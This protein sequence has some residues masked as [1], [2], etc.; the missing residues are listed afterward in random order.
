[1]KYFL[2][3]LVMN[4][5][6]GGSGGV[7]PPAPAPAAPPPAAASEAAPAPSAAATPAGGAAQPPAGDIYKPDGLAEHF[8]G[9][10][11]NETIDNLNKA[12]SGYRDRDAANKVPETVEAYSEFGDIAPEIAPHLETL[13]GDP[14]YGRMANYALEN[15]IPLPIYQGMVKQFMSVGQELGMLEPPVD[16]AKERAELTPEAARHLPEAEQR[17]QREKRMNDNYAFV[18]GL[19]AS[20][21]ITKDDADFAKAMLGDTARGHRFLEAF[22]AVTGNSQQVYVGATAP[23][24]GDPK[25]DLERRG[26]LPQNT[27]GHKDFDRA[28]WDQLQTDYR[29]HYGS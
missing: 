19:V 23:N 7:T 10:S 18:D 2:D 9:K 25:A 15:K 14:I 27:V 20:N 21:K 29:K 1:M 8:L 26:A 12:L 3:R 24:G 16:E 22:R 11:N 13:K 6:G 17:V 5:E 4:S 28:S